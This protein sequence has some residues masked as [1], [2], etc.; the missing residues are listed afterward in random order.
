MKYGGF[1]DLECWKMARELRNKVRI[2]VRKFPSEEKFRLTAQIIAS[3]RSVTSN[4]AEGY[5]RYTYSD[6]RH[7]FVHA[8]GSV[9]ETMDHLTVALDENYITHVELDELDVICETVFKLINGYIAYLDRVK[10][11]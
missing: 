9:T 10:L 5:G 8:R 3:T 6:T 11:S 1:K 2:L 4:I 7:F